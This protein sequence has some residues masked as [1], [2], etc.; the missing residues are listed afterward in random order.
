MG[1]GY[2]GIGGMRNG[3]RQMLMAH[4]VS[5]QL[6][7]GDI[8]EGLYVCHSCD[9][10]PCVNPRHLYLADVRVNTA[11]ATTRG[12]MRRGESHPNSKLTEERVREIRLRYRA[13]VVTQAELAEEYGVKRNTISR[14]VSGKRWGW[15]S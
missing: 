1:A 15:L 9:N 2:G 7:H 11:D 3:K 14:I 10:P 8:P 13:G 12:R 4:R 6:H 5:W